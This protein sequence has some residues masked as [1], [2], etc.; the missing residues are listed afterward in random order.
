[1]LKKGGKL[2]TFFQHYFWIA[3]FLSMTQSDDKSRVPKFH[4]H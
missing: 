3:S 2:T 4:I 1:M